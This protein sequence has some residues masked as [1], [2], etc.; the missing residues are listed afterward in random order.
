M[1]LTAQRNGYWDSLKF[2]LIFLVVL[3]HVNGLCREISTLN[4]A[5]DNFIYLFHMPLFVFISG[6]FSVIRNRGGYKT[7]IIKLLETFL[8]F[9][10]LWCLINFFIFK[11][12]VTI[13]ALI[14]PGPALWYLL[15]LAYWRLFVLYTPKRLMENKTLVISFS[16]IVAV[17]GGFL[18]LGMELSIQKT[19]FFFP[20]FILGYFF[21][22]EDLKIIFGRINNLASWSVIILVFLLF[23][24]VFKSSVLQYVFT[25]RVPYYHFGDDKIL[26]FLLGRLLFYVVAS[27]MGIMFMRI[28][29]NNIIFSKWGM[30]TLVIYIY[31]MFLVCYLGVCFEHGYL[32]SNLFLLFVYSI[33]ITALLILFSRWKLSKWLLNPVSNILTQ[34]DE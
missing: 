33:C 11:K 6:H 22:E 1:T 23:C 17:L 2:F 30:C 14:S 16:V 15:S 10:I 5:V 28:I 32:S 9:H 4:L 21:K 27:L 13:I 7:K 20:F 26:I 29:P 24:T 12:N 3:G 25:G 34:K 18:P 31:H 8:V 19:L